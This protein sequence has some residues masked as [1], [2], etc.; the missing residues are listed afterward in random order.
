MSMS[1]PLYTNVDTNVANASFSSVP[2]DSV[3]AEPSFDG[4]PNGARL[5]A[6]R[7][8]S[9]RD[10]T[11]ERD[12]DV[13]ERVKRSSTRIAALP[14]EARPSRRQSDEAPRR[15]T[16]LEAARALGRRSVPSSLWGAAG[17]GGRDREIPEWVLGGEKPRVTG[18]PRMTARERDT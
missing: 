17:H 13:D 3:I 4:V 11:N 2:A 6:T 1:A 12:D 8:T 5:V 16:V 9:L 18:E 14:E 15:E 10:V 7:E